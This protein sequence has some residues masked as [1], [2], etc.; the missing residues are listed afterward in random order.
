MSNNLV[1][2]RYFF[3]LDLIAVFV[4]LDMEECVSAILLQLI[5][6]PFSPAVILVSPNV[7][8]STPPLLPLS[9]ASP[10]FVYLS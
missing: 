6:L 1:T 5:P 8:L 10:L 3:L 9:I 4:I 2:F 7:Y